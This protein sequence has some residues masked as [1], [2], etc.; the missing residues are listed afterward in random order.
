M[1]IDE[2]TRDEKLQYHVSREIAKHQ[3]YGQAKLVKMSM[4]QV[5]KYSDQSQMIEQSKFHQEKLKKNK[6]RGLK[7]KKKLRLYK[8]AEQ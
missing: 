8:P 2:K 7:S 4:L 5:K 1:T 6:Q 3:L